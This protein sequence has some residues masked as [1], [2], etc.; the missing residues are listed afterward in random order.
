MPSII[1]H[2]HLTTSDDFIELLRSFFFY[3]EIFEDHNISTPK[4]FKSL[5]N[6]ILDAG[7]CDNLTCL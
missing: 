6:C 5:M 2:K 4:H 7:L 3:F 1:S